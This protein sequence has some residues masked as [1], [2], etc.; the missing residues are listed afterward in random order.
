MD[1]TT[2]AHPEPGKHDS[3]LAA[4]VRVLGPHRWFTG[5]LALSIV[6]FAWIV[7]QGSYSFGVR[8]P[9][10]DFYD[11]QAASLLQGRLDVP[12]EAIGGEAFVVGG[13]LYGYFGPVP[14]LLRLPFVWLDVAFGRLARGYMLVFFAGTVIASYLILR[15]AV[16]LVRGP[17]AE[18]SPFAQV[19]LLC[20]A[21]LGSSFFFL[22]SRAYTYHEAILG[23]GMFALFAC[24]CALRHL[25]SP[26]GR[27]WIGALACGLAAVH[28]RPP[29]GLFALTFLGCVALVLARR[30]PRARLHRPLLLAVACTV[31]VL[32]F[33]GLSYLKFRTFDGAPL[34]LSR[35]YDAARLAKIEGKSFHLSNLPFN[36]YT[37][38]VRPNF[39]IEARFPWLYLGRGIPG[40]YF[41]AA[42][43]DLADETLAFPYAMPGF[44]VLA[45][46]AAAWAC[47]RHPS[48]RTPVA[49]AWLGVAP[50]TLALFTAVATAERYTADFVPFFICAAAFGLVALE[51]AAPRWRTA[52]RLALGAAT[53][54]ACLLSVA[55]ALHYQRDSV[56]GV[57]EEVRQDYQNLRRRI[58]TFFGQRPPE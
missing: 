42:K 20:G 6:A 23:G 19:V 24:W 17:G 49:V 38:L 3:L 7:T 41:P 36:S 2:R 51:S 22:G 27:W 15:H 30:E 37:Y 46:L 11:Y 16:G 5:V 57:P 44:F 48:V 33:N 58:D 28:T 47:V 54:W 32:T 43:T 50:M 31:A 56:W 4:A 8:E 10:G 40:Y 18:P 14:A 13:K 34:H 26:A 45:T 25:A 35:P 21:G 12:E 52:G 55:M 39:R 29:A 53:L 9:F 1:T